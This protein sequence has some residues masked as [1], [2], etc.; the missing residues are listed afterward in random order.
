MRSGKIKNFVSIIIRRACTVCIC[1]PA[2]EGVSNSCKN[3]RGQAL[4]LVVFEALICHRAGCRGCVLIELYGVRNR[5]PLCVNIQIS[6]ATRGD[7]GNLGS[8]IKSVA[9]IPT[10]EDVTFTS[11]IFQINVS[12]I[13][14]ITIG[15]CACVLTTIQMI[16]DVISVIIPVSNVFLITN[17]SG[18]NNHG[19]GRFANI[20]SCPPKESIANSCGS[21]QNNII[22]RYGINNRV[23]RCNRTAL[24]VV[25][26]GI[27][28]NIPLCR[29]SNV[30]SSLP[31]SAFNL[32]LAKIPTKEIVTS[33]S[34]N[35]KSILTI[36]GHLGRSVCNI[37]ACRAIGNGVCFSSPRSNYDFVL[38]YGSS[39]VIIPCGKIVALSCSLGSYCKRTFF[40]LLCINAH[41]ACRVKNNIVHRLSSD[42]ERVELC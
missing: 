1:G 14:I 3:V 28:A 37:P 32:F 41:T 2:N 20:C 27:F 22:A 21:C 15:I 4:S 36:K 10:A 12:G 9:C 16:S 39:K 13:Y 11:G 30:G 38:H 40:D 31:Y 33:A 25:A 35:L 7:N 6:R 23:I 34:R 5:S 29:Q 8:S 18:I 19:H 42:F 17:A 26:N 24:K